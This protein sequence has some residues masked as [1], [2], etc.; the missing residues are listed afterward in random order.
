MS[1]FS[2]FCSHVCVWSGQYK[3]IGWKIQ[4]NSDHESS[5]SSHVSRPFSKVQLVTAMT[6]MLNQAWSFFSFTMTEPQLLPGKSVKPKHACYVSKDYRDDPCV[7]RLTLNLIFLSF[8]KEEKYMVWK[9]TLHNPLA[10][11]WQS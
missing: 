10:A 3:F 9:L 5:F 7:P 8:L 2:F 4:I 6:T 1:R 11:F